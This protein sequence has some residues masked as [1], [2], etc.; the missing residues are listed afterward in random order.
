[1]IRPVRDK[2]KLSQAFSVRAS[3]SKRT[4][5]RILLVEDEFHVLLLVQRKL[6]S[7][8][9][10]VTTADHGDTALELAL[11]TRPDLIL[12][13]IMLPGRNGLDICREVK[14][15]LG[16]DAPRV[17]LM[18]ARGQQEDVEAG[19]EAGADDYIIKPFSPRLLLERVQALLND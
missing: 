17:I 5:G 16:S 10:T 14:T 7:A 9:Y 4:M 18:S 2:G 8:G 11:Q 12:L 13:D 1:L 15:T 6:E 19:L 3:M